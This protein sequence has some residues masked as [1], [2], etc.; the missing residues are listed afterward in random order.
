[1]FCHCSRLRSSVGG[2]ELSS[3]RLCLTVEAVFQT[4]PCFGDST[5]LFL[6]LLVTDGSSELLW[7]IFSRSL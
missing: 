5:R 7:T 2:L 3:W 6:Y 1:M 4:P